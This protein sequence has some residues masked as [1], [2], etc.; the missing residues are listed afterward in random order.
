MHLMYRMQR[1]LYNMYYSMNLAYFITTEMRAA[2]HFLADKSTKT[3]R[4]KA[5]KG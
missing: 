4:I 2:M 1:L 5:Y 3:P